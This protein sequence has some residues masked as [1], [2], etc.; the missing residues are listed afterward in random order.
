MVNLLGVHGV[1]DTHVIS[2]SGNMF[3]NIQNVFKYVS[4]HFELFEKL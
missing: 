4:K 2:Q 1:D 3:E